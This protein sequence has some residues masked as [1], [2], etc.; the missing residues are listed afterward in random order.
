MPGLLARRLKVLID[1]GFV[2]VI[3]ATS[4]LSEGVNIPANYLLI[5]SVYRYGD[6]LSLQEFTNLI[7]RAGRPGFGTEGSALVV[8]PERK[9]R[10]DGTLPD[11]PTRQWAG[12]RNLIGA[13]EKATIA[14]ATTSSE[15]QA[16]S[17]LAHLL[18]AL[19]SAW[20]EL[21]GE[22][23]D[24]EFL[25]WLE[26]TAVIGTPEDA[27]SA[28]NYL[29]ILDSFLITT[30]QEVEVLRKS[31]IPPDQMEDELIAI[32]RRT[33][34]FAASQEESRL[35]EIWLARG[36]AIKNV[37]RDA[38]QRQRIYKTSLSPRSATTLIELARTMRA[39]LQDGVAY[40]RWTS[41]ER[42]AFVRDIIVV[43]SEVS[44][45]RIS[46]TLGRRR[47]PDWPKVLRWWLAKQT[48]DT[49]PEPN[50]ITN[51]YEFVAQNF[52]YRAAWGLGSLIGLLLDGEDGELSIRALEIDDWPRSGLPWIA[53][54]MKDL[55]TWG[56]LDPV[57]AFLLARGDAID[58]PQAE[59]EAQNY[60][61]IWPKDSDPNDILD[62]RQI[63]DWIGERRAHQNQAEAI[64][65]L[66]IG[67]ELT[68]P[69]TEYLSSSLWVTPISVDDDFEWI[70][71][72]GYTVAR[73]KKPPSWPEDSLSIEFRLGVQ[74]SKVVGSPYIQPSSKTE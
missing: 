40:A 2:R 11:A 70:D 53:F 67:V 57:A 73:S 49:Q 26:R 22:G 14:S 52:I 61:E 28:Y 42:F 4:T 72:A 17:P 16:S 30:I 66:E 35:A 45:F 74:Q 54:W 31:E 62:P 65:E 63:R 38:A 29:D 33:Y 68:H 36:R 41:E 71:P 13:V 9:R 44:P 15:D 23:T 6:P 25:V 58:R 19:K 24:Q 27:G 3:I 50:Q 47:F 48:L 37:Y 60:Y 69:I 59:A 10:Y 18:S 5:P 21:V 34:A 20:L 32:W 7:G 64:T 39:K 1:R 46:S 56:T 43:L 51:W 55:L 12:Y 8:L